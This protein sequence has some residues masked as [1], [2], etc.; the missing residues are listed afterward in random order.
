MKPV[1]L[2][3]D[4]L[5]EFV[6]GRLRSPEAEVLIPR[7]SLLLREARRRGILVV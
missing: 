2:V 5:E 7:I 4:M 1:L 6:R 3:I